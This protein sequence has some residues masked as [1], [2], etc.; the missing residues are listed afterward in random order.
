[1]ANMLTTY[2]NTT[3]Q[4][5]MITDYISLIDPHDAVAIELL[6]GLDGARSK[7]SFTTANQTKVEWLTDELYPLSSSLA[8]AMST[9]TE[10]TV[11]VASGQG[12]RF[13]AGDILQIDSEGMYVTSVAGDNLTVTRAFFGAAATHAASAAIA[14]TGQAR[15]SGADSASRAIPEITSDYNYTSI[16]HEEVSASGSDLSIDYYGLDNILEYK[17]RM[18]IPHLTRLLEKNLYHSSR[19]AGSATTPRSAGFFDA[20]ITASTTYNGINAAGPIAEAHLRDA[21][22]A[23]Y[24]DGGSGPWLAF[25]HPNNMGNL[26]ALYNSSSL[27]RIDRDETTMG[28]KLFKYSGPYGDIDFVLDRWAPTD[29]IYIIDP[30]H[31]GFITLRPWQREQLAH[32]GDAYSEQV[33]GEFSFAIRHP[34]TAHAVIYG[35]T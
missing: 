29:K 24:M 18:V 1:M 20:F 2:Q 22:K 13:K 35:L 7:F 23:A 16:Y 31:A 11:A 14:I 9:T 8:T 17:A 30:K 32:T 28:M 15:L 19:N 27:L 3:A 33:I 12:V 4:V 21:T 5:R 34:N 25:F 6:G 26:V 10:T